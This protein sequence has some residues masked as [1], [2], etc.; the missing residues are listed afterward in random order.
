[1]TLIEKLAVLK[2]AGYEV[3]YRPTT[4]HKYPWD[5]YNPSTSNESL[6]FYTTK[7]EAV[8]QALARVLE[9]SKR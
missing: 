2:M 6:S 7:I 8:N 3:R 9:H 1:M 5:W 4:N